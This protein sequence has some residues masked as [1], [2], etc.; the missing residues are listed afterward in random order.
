MNQ[1]Y[2]AQWGRV[3]HAH[4][5]PWACH[6][7]PRGRATQ[8]SAALKV[9]APAAGLQLFDHFADGFLVMFAGDER[10]AGRVDDDAVFDAERDD[11]VLAA[12][13]DDAAA[14]ADAE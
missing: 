8:P 6:P 1:G 7:N 12:G 3:P 9:I 13:A 5:K 11:Q 10:G 4:A 14:C 2:G